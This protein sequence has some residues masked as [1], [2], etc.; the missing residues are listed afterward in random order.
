MTLFRREPKD[1][2]AAEEEEVPAA[3]LNKKISVNKHRKYYSFSIANSFD[4]ERFLNKRELEMLDFVVSEYGNLG[5]EKL[6][7]LSYKTEPMQNAK[8]DEE[9]N[10]RYIRKSIQDK[11]SKVKKDSLNN[12]SGEPPEFKDNDEFLDYQYKIMSS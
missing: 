12:Y 9:L 4:F 7:E 8:E 6:T 1:A 11:I 10:F 5:Y 2:A 3:G